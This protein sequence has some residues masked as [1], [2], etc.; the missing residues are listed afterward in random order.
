HPSRCCPPP[1]F[2]EFTHTRAWET[3]LPA[4]HIPC[5]PGALPQGDF[6]SQGAR[7][8][9]LLQPSQAAQAEGISQ[10]APALGALCS[11]PWLLRKWGC[12]TLRLLG[13][14][15]P[16]TNDRKT[17]T[18]N[19]A[20]CWARAQWDSLGPLKLSHRAK[21]CWTTHVPAE[22]LVGLEPQVSKAA[23]E[24]EDGAP[25]SPEPATPEACERQAHMQAIQAPSQPLQET[26]RSS[27]LP[28]SLVD[29]VLSTLEFQQKAQP[30]LDPAPLG[31]LKDVE[32]PAPLELLLSQEEH[33]ALLQ[34]L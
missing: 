4:P 3:G 1:S 8:V 2:I 34:E 27:A 12:P 5:A 24:P 29:E 9:P 16:P 11:V 7:A 14:P 28:S 31:E 13:G 17:R 32:Q 30:L 18:R 20:A 10:P 33:P 23:W 26:Q 6:V 21:V 25:P 15:A 19:T 22:S